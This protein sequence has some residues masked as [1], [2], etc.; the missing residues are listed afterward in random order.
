[1]IVWDGDGVTGGAG[2]A[3]PDTNPF[4][5]QTTVAHQGAA[6]FWNVIPQSSPWSEWGWNWKAWQTPGTDVSKA[7]AFTFFLRLAGNRPPDDIVVTLRSSINQKYAHQPPKDGGLRG[8]SL[9]LYEP[10]FAD[11][12]WHRITIPMGDILSD[13]V[14]ADFA[15]VYEV[16]MGAGGSDYQLYLDDIGFIE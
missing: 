9:R 6:L 11:G 13:D 3:T 5:V 12:T 1:M 4:T 10:S 2:W 8:V 7:T 14:A 16:F 15:Q